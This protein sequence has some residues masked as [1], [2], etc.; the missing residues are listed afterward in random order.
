MV[1]ILSSFPRLLL[2]EHFILQVQ[3]EGLAVPAELDIDFVDVL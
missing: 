1:F 2:L 3:L